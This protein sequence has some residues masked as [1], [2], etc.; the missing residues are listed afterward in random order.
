MDDE[1]DGLGSRDDGGDELIEVEG[2][3]YESIG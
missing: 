3:F 1:D 2:M